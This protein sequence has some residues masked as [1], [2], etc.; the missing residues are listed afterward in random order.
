M[1]VVRLGAT[2]ITVSRL[3]L[4][5]GT[6]DE[7]GRCQQARMNERQFLA[8]LRVAHERGITHWDTSV[9]YGTHRVLG[10]ALQE[11][12]RD[13]VS[14]TTK[15]SSPDAA[16]ARRDLEQALKDLGTDYVDVCLMHAVRNRH[17]FRSRAGVLEELG[18]AKVAGKIRALG[19]SSHGLQALELGLETPGIEVVWARINYAGLAMDKR[20]LGLYDWLASRPRLKRFVN[21]LPKGIMVPA[22][23]TDSRPASRM[24][25]RETERLLA[26]LSASGKGVVGMKIFGEGQLAQEPTRVWDCV[27]RLAYLDAFVVGML[28]PQQIEINC[29]LLGR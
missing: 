14:L 2:G 17:D 1:Q 24:D 25:R 8:L 10:R 6:A 4:G 19:L 12:S 27:S 29:R 9:S 3:G 21:V 23:P 7:Q 11:I 28:T 16:L 22:R 18:K 13:Q 26:E 20:Q 5:T 15:L